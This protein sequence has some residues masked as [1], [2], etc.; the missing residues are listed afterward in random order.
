MSALVIVLVIL[1]LLGLAVSLE[2]LAQHG[3]GEGFL[4]E[5]F[6]EEGER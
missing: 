4:A 6:G 1:A 5:W 3:A 2:R